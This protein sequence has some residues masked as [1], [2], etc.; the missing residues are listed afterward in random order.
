RFEATK[1]RAEQ[2]IPLSAKAAAAIRA[3]QEHVLSTWPGGSPW[4]FPGIVGNDDGH[5]PYSHRTLCQQLERWQQ[6]IGLRDQAGR[7]VTVTG[8]QF[9]HTLGTG[10][11]TAASPSTA[12]KSSSLTPPR[13]RPRTTPA[14]TTPP[15]AKSSTAT[16]SSGSTSP[17]RSSATTRMR[18]PRPLN[19]SS[20]TCPGSAT[21]CPTGTAGGRPSKTA[22]TP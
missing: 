17:G 15:S 7:P 19:G 6:V 3:Q 14:S 2:L 1:V 13:T 16:S 4:L 22:R 18:R 11:S 12:C 10:S 9:R 20:T 8:H 5:K 21:A